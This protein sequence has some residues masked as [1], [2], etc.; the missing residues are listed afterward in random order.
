MLRGEPPD[1]KDVVSGTRVVAIVPVFERP[2]AV[3]EALDSIAAQTRAPDAIVVVDDGSQDETADRVDEWIR[4]QSGPAAARSVRSPHRGV[5]S[6]RNVGL[7][8]AAE[9]DW[10]AFLDSDDRWAPNYLEAHLARL[11]S[12]ENVVAGT[13]DKASLDVPTGRR[14]RVDRAWV[15]RDTTLRIARHGPPGISNSVLRASDV[16]ALGGFR[17][18]LQTAEDLDLMLR[19]SCRGGWAHVSGTTTE[20]RHRLGESWGEAPSLGHVHEDR[21]RTRAEVLDE[22]SVDVCS[23]DPVLG[24][25]LTR[26]AAE[27]WGRAGRQLEAAGRTS[28]ARECFERALRLR[29]SAWRSRFAAW[30]LRT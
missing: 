19:L 25:A 29:P 7:A 12:L 20:Y 10:I 15:E 26:L 13:C 23:S 3:V 1:T 14:R 22:F 17:E 8:E 2:R 30:R 9:A 16:R 18:S 28:E 4:R 11:E 27:Q 6:A 21:R 5:S 24:R